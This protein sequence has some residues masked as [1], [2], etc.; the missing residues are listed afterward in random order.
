LLD[1][2]PG[3][4]DAVCHSSKME[5]I[6]ESG[7]EKTVIPMSLGNIPFL[8][9]G[10]NI[11]SVDKFTLIN[12]FQ[13][14]NKEEQYVWLTLSFEYYDGPRPNFKDTKIIWLSVGPDICNPKAINPFGP[15]N[16]T[17]MGVPKSRAFE[18]SSIPWKSF[19]NGRIIGGG[20]FS[21]TN[22]PH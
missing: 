2:G 10:Y 18:E 6:F 3:I 12:E 21:Q 11:K 22:T 16:M 14:Q 19:Y 9:T 5:S 8:K 7:N 1:E 4:V 13:N 15:S 20:K 17:L